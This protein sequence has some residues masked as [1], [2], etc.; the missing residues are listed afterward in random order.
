M[1]FKEK[2]VMLTYLRVALAGQRRWFCASGM[3]GI[4]TLA[5]VAM[6]LMLIQEAPG[7]TALAPVP[8]ISTIAGNGTGADAGDGGQ[9]LKAELRGSPLCVAVDKAGNMYISDSFDYVIRKVSKATGIISTIAGTAGTAGN[10]TNS[11]DGG[12]ATSALVNPQSVSIDNNGNLLITDYVDSVIRRIDQNGIIT[13]VAGMY[14]KTGRTGDGH[15]ATSA[16]LYHPTYAMTDV[17]GN[18]YIADEAN[19]VIRKVS[20]NGIITTIA[21]TAGTHGYTGDGGLATAATLYEPY[22]LWMDWAGD[23]FVSDAYGNNVIRKIDP[24]GIIT[25]FAGN[26]KQGFIGNGGPATS[27][28]FYAPFGG[29]TDAFGNNYITDHNNEAIRVVNT[30]G[31]ISEFAGLGGTAGQ[32]YG[33]DGGPALTA[34]INGPANIAMDA[35]NNMY[36][37]DSGTNRVR[38]V[39]LNMNFPSTAVASSASQNIFVQSSSAVTP[40]TAT[41]TPVT[42]ATPAV[43]TLGTLSGCTLG[44]PLAASTPCT[45]PITFQPAAPGL[46]TAQ[47]AFTDSTGYVS[48]LGLSGVGVAPEVTFG[49]AAISTIA[50]NGI[51][52]STGATGPAASAQVSAPRGGVIDSA[53]NIYFADS[54]N[55]IVRRIDAVTGAISTAAGTGTAGYAGDGAAATAAQLNSPAKVAVDAAG[56]LYIADTGNSVIR[57]VNA[58]TGFI[59]TIAGVGTAGYT[60]DG[61]MATAA[62]LN[63]PQG[64]AIDLGAHVYVADTGNNVIRYFGNGGLITTLTGT[65]TAGYI[66]DGGN[67]YGA[68]LN[69]PQSVALDGSGNVY[70]AD[71]GNDIVR[72]ISGTNQISTF[73]GQQGIAVNAGDGGLATQATLSQPSDIVLDAAGDLYIAAGGQIRMVNTASVISTLAGTGAAGSYSGEGGAATSAVLPSPVSNLMLD[74]A[75]NI[76]LSDTAGNRL[77]K[78]ATATPMPLDLGTG[79]PGATSAGKTLSILNT[80]NSALNITGV[81]VS[82]GFTLQAAGTSDCTAATSLTPGQSCSLSIAFSPGSSA[83]GVVTGA[84]TLTD[85]ALNGAGVTQ[86]IGL[87]GTAKVIVSTTTVVSVSSISLVYGAPA[88]TAIAMVNGGNA[89]TGTVSFSVNGTSIGGV[90]LS[91]NQ[92]TIVLPNLPAGR[93]D[94]V[95]SYA[96]DDNNGSSSGTASITIQPAV[97][98]VTAAS[99]TITYG[100]ALPSLTYTITGLVNGDGASVI[101]GAPVET[102]TATATSTVGSYPITITQGTLTVSNYT[103]SFVNGTLTI[104]PPPSPDYTLTVTPASTSIPAG[105]VDYVTLTLTPLYGYKGTVS[106]SC[107]SLPKSVSCA[108]TGPLA[109]DGLG[110]PAWT[111]V[112]IYTNGRNV[113]SSRNNAPFSAPG[114]WFSLGIPLCFV[115]LGLCKDRRRW[116]GRLLG[117]FLIVAFTAGMSSCSQGGGAAA[118]AGTYSI[119]VTAADTSAN[120]SHAATFTLTIQ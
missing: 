37:G 17:A 104:K 63:H 91:N 61:G 51:A 109:G 102:T 45:V 32:G 120:L 101:A 41:I 43:F 38:F 3:F 110:D 21:G 98:T 62:S 39:S 89:P 94:I 58:T 107:G 59:S 79:T 2:F 78:I 44:V 100:A 25:T 112:I 85:N 117:L 73:A 12:S 52:G 30:S 70:I 116:A 28:E 1:Y 74:S 82:A 75:A 8:V 96:G 23:L 60:G 16:T 105:Q 49:P 95:A 42:S 76:V 34:K 68:E 50:G 10:S 84:L 106:L 80:G 56:D 24:K 87:S 11:G 31:V 86:T 26:G 35:L 19:Y 115:G 72:R 7:Q 92:A 57:Y 53:G 47:L 118:P 77:L 93:A 13:T 4:V 15:A 103:F 6:F 33:G 14:G 71:T 83:N 55:H 66:G 119:V 65:G 90:T 113:T 40:S 81:N 46:Q 64:L 108:F 97:L 48:I 69:A 27:A 9:A 29:L 18:I 20:P 67:A 99:A 111:Q 114:V 5:V 54:G 88:A 36:I 22:F